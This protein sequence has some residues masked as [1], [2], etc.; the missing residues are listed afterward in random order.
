MKKLFWI[1]LAF[2]VIGGGALT[3]VEAQRPQHRAKQSKQAQARKPGGK[4]HYKAAHR[5]ER[6]QKRGVYRHEGPAHY[7]RRQAYKQ[8]RPGPHHPP[9]QAGYER[10]DRP[11]VARHPQPVHRRPSHYRPPHWARAHRYQ[12]KHPVYFRDYHMFYDP[13]RNGYVYYHNSRWL[14]SPTVPAFV[15]HVDL[16]RAHIQ[17]LSELPLRAR[18]ELYYERYARR[19]PAQINI[20]IPLPPLPGF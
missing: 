13:Y 5:G 7:D 8:R 3:P 20:N 18:P 17:I 9:R 2:F 4:A 6:F 14:F 15:A 16:G 11:H 19:Y 10:R 12:A 1:L